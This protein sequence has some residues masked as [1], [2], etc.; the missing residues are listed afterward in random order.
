MRTKLSAVSV[1]ER[2]HTTHASQAAVRVLIAPTG[3]LCPLAVTTPLY[4]TTVSQTLPTRR[5]E[6]ASCEATARMPPFLT[7]PS[8]ASSPREHNLD[9]RLLTSR[10]RELLGSSPTCPENGVAYQ[11]PRHATQ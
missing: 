10:V 8:V 5:Y 11:H 3:C 9:A 1:I 7:P 2:A 6:A 4:S